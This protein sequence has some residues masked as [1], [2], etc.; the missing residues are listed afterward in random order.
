[1]KTQVKIG[2]G[3]KTY[4]VRVSRAK[5][6][7]GRSRVEAV[8]MCRKIYPELEKENKYYWKTHM[9]HHIDKNPFNN[10]PN[11][12]AIILRNEH[13]IWHRKKYEWDHRMCLHCNKETIYLNNRCTECRYRES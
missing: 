5:L 11:N 7:T 10:D 1:M 12:L 3:Y 4:R 13:W 8:R 6:T 2:L 9:V